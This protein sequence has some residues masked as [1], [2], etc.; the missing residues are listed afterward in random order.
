VIHVDGRLIG[1][2]L[3][4]TYFRVDVLP[5]ERLLHGIGY[6]QGSIKVN[7]RPDEIAFVSLDAMGGTSHFR[8]VDPETAKR[9]ILRCCSLMENWAPGLRPLFR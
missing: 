6:D 3:P 8:Q 5:G 7:V 1:A 2:T 4:R 9:E